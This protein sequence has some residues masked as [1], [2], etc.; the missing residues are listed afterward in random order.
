MTGRTKRSGFDLHWYG[1]AVSPGKEDRVRK[2]LMKQSRIRDQWHLVKAVLMPRKKA[3]VMRKGKKEI[4]HKKAMP[5]YLLIHCHYCQ[6]VLALVRSVK[7]VIGFLPLGADP[8]D[9]PK[10]AP[11][12][13]DEVAHMLRLTE[14][15]KKIR[16]KS[17][18]PSVFYIDYKMD[19]RVLLLDGSV[20]PGM[21][22]VCV[23]ID[24]PRPGAEP[25]VTVELSIL[26]QAKRVEVPYFL[27]KRVD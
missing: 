4:H 10:P 14:Q 19:D 24:E 12:S 13:D 16:D 27:L 9:R 2:D 25:I 6:D 11:L 3:A 5:G 15:N 1:L 18:A 21:E 8:A 22:G 17:V 7:H 26:G 20:V 23:D